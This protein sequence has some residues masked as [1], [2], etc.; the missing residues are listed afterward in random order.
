M[1]LGAIIETLA[2]KEKLGLLKYDNHAT[3]WYGPAVSPVTGKINRNGTQL[4]AELFVHLL[5]GGTPDEQKR[6]EL[7]EKFAE[8]RRISDDNN[9][10]RDLNGKTVRLDEI[11]LPTP[12]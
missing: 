8:S 9:S 11:D 4:C 5:G 10:G 2:K 3:P 7:R 12:W 1:K 6:N